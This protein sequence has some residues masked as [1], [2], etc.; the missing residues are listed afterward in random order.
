MNSI[1]IVERVFGMFGQVV[2]AGGG[3]AVV[4]FLLFKYLGKGWIESQLAKDLELAKA[5]IGLLSA[6]KLKL[7]DREYVVF[8]KI[9][10]KL[11]KAYASLGRA[12]IGFREVPNLDKYSKDEIA[13]WLKGSDLSEAEK[14]RFENEGSDIMALN[15]ILDR[16]ELLAAQRDFF[17][18]HEELTAE[19]I[20]LS[21]D[22]KGKLEKVGGLLRSSWANKK[23]DFDGHSS[24][25]FLSA[26]YKIY[27]DEAKP[28]IGEI[29]EIFRARIFPAAKD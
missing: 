22:L 21:P 10:S 17:D 25:D 6:R 12:V 27:E 9:W 4:A 15:R 19:K 8:P 28:V 5:E 23:M 29:E 1:E 13:S 3:G 2:I 11:N 7:H 20:F 18:F 24:R 14:T 26:A 16:R